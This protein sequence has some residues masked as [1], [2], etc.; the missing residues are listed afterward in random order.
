MNIPTVVL[1]QLSNQTKKYTWEKE[2][3]KVK[4]NI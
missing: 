1:Q 3:N 2:G 4:I